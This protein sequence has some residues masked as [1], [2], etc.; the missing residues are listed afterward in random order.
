MLQNPRMSV[1]EARAS[2][3]QLRD[4]TYGGISYQPAPRQWIVE[5]HEILTAIA[6]REAQQLYRLD[7]LHGVNMD[8]LHNRVLD[9]L[10]DFEQVVAKRK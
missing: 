2:L 5:L 7:G 4:V 9:V 8:Y 6:T 3:E 10:R 1:E